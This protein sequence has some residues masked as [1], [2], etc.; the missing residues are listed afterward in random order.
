MAAMWYDLVT[1]NIPEATLTKKEKDRNG[2][3]SFM[4]AH[5]FLWTYSYPH[6][7]EVLSRQGF[8]PLGRVDCCAESKE[9]RAAIFI[10]MVDGTDCRIWERQH[11]TMKIDKG[12]NSV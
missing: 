2:F 1:T 8:L 5:H 12:F 6:R 7:R 10:V 9:D 4:L 11:P 3:K